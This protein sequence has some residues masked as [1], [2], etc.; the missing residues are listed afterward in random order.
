[1]MAYNFNTGKVEII[2]ENTNVE[3][4]QEEVSGP[5]SLKKKYTISKQESP[6]KKTGALTESKS[7]SKTGKQ[8]QAGKT[9][10]LKEGAGGSEE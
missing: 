8:G 10:K 9:L 6:L 4:S 3:V 5:A 1:M 2:C 7:P